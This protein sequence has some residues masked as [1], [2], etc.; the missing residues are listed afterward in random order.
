MV[1]ASDK[2][3]KFKQFI[4]H[5]LV[6]EKILWTGQPYKGSLYRGWDFVAIPVWGWVIPFCI[7][8]IYAGVKP[9]TQKGDF[10]IDAWAPILVGIVFLPVGFY[11]AFW[12]YVIKKRKMS[13]TYYAVTDK[14]LLM[15]SI[16]S[17]KSELLHFN[18]LPTELNLDFVK[19]IGLQ[20]DRTGTGTLIFYDGEKFST[21]KRKDRMVDD[22]P[23]GGREPWGYSDKTFAFCD[24]KEA[25]KV[26]EIIEKF[27]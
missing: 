16:T 10:S 4:E 26:Y 8:L 23:E 22:L 20:I 6:E 2:Q 11:G 17:G 14:R 21:P 5:L 25:H 9:I 24:I 1:I 18:S 12:K 19:D 3:I 13:R 27:R 15:F 7:A